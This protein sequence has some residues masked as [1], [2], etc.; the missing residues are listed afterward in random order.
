M[1]VIAET[2]HDQVVLRTWIK[3]YAADTKPP[4][5]VTEP[6]AQRMQRMAVKLLEGEIDEREYALDVVI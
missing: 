6:L 1:R 2:E 4:R 3:E 5:S